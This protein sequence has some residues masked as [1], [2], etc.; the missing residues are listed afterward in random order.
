MYLLQVN[1]CV[2]RKNVELD[3]SGYTLNFVVSIITSIIRMNLIVNSTKDF[4]EAVQKMV[5]C[6]S[7]VS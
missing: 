5:E 4:D 2:Q 7:V 3:H 1:W 6:A